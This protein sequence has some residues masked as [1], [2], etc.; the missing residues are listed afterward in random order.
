MK[1]SSLINFSVTPEGKKWDLFIVYLFRIPYFSDKSKQF[2]LLNQLFFIFFPYVDELVSSSA[3]SI[4]EIYRMFKSLLQKGIAK[5][6]LIVI[7]VFLVFF[8][9]VGKSGMKKIYFY[10]FCFFLKCQFPCLDT[11]KNIS[12]APLLSQYHPSFSFDIDM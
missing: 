4:F 5:K 9:L 1:S 10:C 3:D 8:S 11:L 7:R 6:I 2:F 12:M